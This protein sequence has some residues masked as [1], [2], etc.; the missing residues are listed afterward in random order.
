MRGNASFQD[1]PHHV[2]VQLAQCMTYQRCVSVLLLSIVCACVNVCVR[3][4]VRVRRGRGLGGCTFVRARVHVRDHDRAVINA[5]AELLC[6]SCCWIGIVFFS[7][8][9]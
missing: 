2:Q 9:V 7:A 8:Y 5:F 6:C 4:C 1:Y 3:V